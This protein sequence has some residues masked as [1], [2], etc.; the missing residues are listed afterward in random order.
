M[1]VHVI[2]FEPHE[3]HALV[4]FQFNGKQYRQSIRVVEG[5]A[6]P[7]K[8][9]WTKNRSRIERQAVLNWA[10]KNG[11]SLQLKTLGEILQFAKSR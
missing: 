5:S 10:S 7:T 4:A 3:S 8:G 11:T 2:A 1:S 9:Y 6:L